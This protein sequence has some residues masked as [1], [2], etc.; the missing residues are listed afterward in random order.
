MSKLLFKHLKSGVYTSPQTN[1]VQ[2]ERYIV[3]NE[4]D[5]VAYAKCFPA[6][7]VKPFNMYNNLLESLKEGRIII[8]TDTTQSG[9]PSYCFENTTNDT[10]PNS[11]NRVKLN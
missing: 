8:L 10:H 11:F 3:E 1:D 4:A 2:H 7:K 5:L 6:I 9:F